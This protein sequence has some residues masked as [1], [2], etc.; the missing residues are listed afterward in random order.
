M[1]PL[2]VQSA[3]AL[4]NSI[5]NIQWE[6]EPLQHEITEEMGFHL[7]LFLSWSSTEDVAGTRS[8]M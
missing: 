3:P 1:S 8:G 6:T 7:K 5:G 2:C 4:A